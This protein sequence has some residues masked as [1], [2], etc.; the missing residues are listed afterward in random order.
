MKREVRLDLEA[1]STKHTAYWFRALY[2][3][4]TML[5]NE[6]TRHCVII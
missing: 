4:C 2:L 6:Y 5:Y 3:D 1:L